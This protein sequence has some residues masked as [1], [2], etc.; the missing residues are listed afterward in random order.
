MRVLIFVTHLLGTGHLRRALTLGH[1]F[2]DRGHQ[3]NLV[4][5]GAPVTNLNAKGVTL[6]QLPPVKSDGV[7]FV[8]LL[9]TENQEVDEKYL[10]DRRNQACSMLLKLRP[11]VLV[12]ELYPFGRRVLK[13]EFL[14]LLEAADKL[15]VKP[16]ILASI[17][18]ILAPPSKP[19]KAEETAAIVSRFYDAVLV[20]SDPSS[21]PLDVSW[22]VT[23]SLAA[24]LAYTGYVAPAA[25][26]AHPQEIGTGEI[27]VTAGG[28]DVGM[29]LFEVAVAASKLDAKRQWRVLVGGSAASAGIDRL[30][31]LA[32]NSGT[33]IE[34]VRQDFRQMLNH[35][36]ASVSMCGYNTALDLLQ[37]GTPGVF[38]PFDLGGEVEQTLRARSLSQRSGLTMITNADLTPDR[39]LV[40]IDQI[41]TQSGGKPQQTGFDGGNESVRIAERLLEAR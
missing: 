15:A 16:V 33:I 8:R 20:H 19:E 31:M 36:A 26:A 18:D 4:S 2:C 11:D 7:N 29:Q 23:P 12:T 17:R 38:V 14:A 10:A 25:P 30:I 32:G 5:G 22:P 6:L 1:A 13:T 37:T 24:K 34:P 39:L 35:A 3:V 41:T 9:D 21:T 40:A 27:L 28:G